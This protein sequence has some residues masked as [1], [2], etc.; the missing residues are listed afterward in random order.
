[1]QQ[2]IEEQK[3]TN[4][5]K[6]RITVEIVSGMQY[7][8]SKNLIHLALK[9]R[10][11]LLS[12]NKHARISDFGLTKEESLETSQAKEASKLRFIAPELYEESPREQY[13]SKVDVYSFG[14]LFFFL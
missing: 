11:I 10:N 8:H 7:I 2:P 14:I 6:N 1:M 9:P 3:L 4:E 12:K 13:D 5:E